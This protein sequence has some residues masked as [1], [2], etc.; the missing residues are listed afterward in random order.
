MYVHGHARRKYGNH[1]TQTCKKQIDKPQSTFKFLF[2]AKIGYN[3]FR[4]SYMPCFFK[5]RVLHIITVSRHGQ[6]EY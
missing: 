5:F 6:K 3:L 4:L 2:F 1:S